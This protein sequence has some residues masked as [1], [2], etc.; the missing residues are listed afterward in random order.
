MKVIISKPAQADLKDIA[1]YIGRDK[2]RRGRTYALQLATQARKL[3]LFPERYAV[4][5]AFPHV[6]RMPYGNYNI[7]YR[8]GTHEVVVL[9]V[10]HGARLTSPELFR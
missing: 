10:I 1:A 8:V 9:R 3:N 2:K 4:L 5:E 7:F 6:R